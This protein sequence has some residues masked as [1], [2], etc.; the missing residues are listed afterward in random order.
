MKKRIFDWIRELFLPERKQPDVPQAQPEPKP[1]STPA[2]NPEPKVEACPRP[3]YQSPDFLSLAKQCAMGDMVAM[4]ELARWHRRHIRPS[5]EALFAAYEAGDDSVYGELYSRLQR[6]YTDGH[7][8]NAYITW[9][10]RAALYGNEEAVAILDRCKLYTTFGCIKPKTFTPGVFCCELYYSSDLHR[11]GL[12]D[13]DSG[14]DEFHLYSL[15]TTGI[16][17]ACY[18]SDYIPADSD[19]FGRE[20]EYSDLFYDEFFNYL[21]GD[22]KKAQDVL[23][24]MKAKR[25]AYWRIPAHDAEHRKYRRLLAES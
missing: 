1:E 7:P 16:Y 21:S 23:P 15:R 4:L 10:T 11:L 20:D 5:S 6:N 8:C 9:V 19:G 17:R 14:L 2:A 18:L 3:D 22:Y 13:I 12:M 25:D 24:A